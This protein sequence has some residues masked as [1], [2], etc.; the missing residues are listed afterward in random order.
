MSGF[1]FPVFLGL[2]LSF[3]RRRP[4]IGV[5]NEHDPVSDEY[6]ILNRH[7]FAYESVAG[8]LTVSPTFA[9]FWISTNAPITVRS[10]ISQP[11]KLINFDNLTLSPSLTS[12]EMH[13]YVSIIELVICAFARKN[14]GGSLQKNLYVKPYGPGGSVL[15]VQTDHIIEFHPASAANLPNPVIP[16]LTVSNRRLCHVS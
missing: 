12:G 10:P 8:D 13:R 3:G 6:V 15:E 1:H 5:V 14:S 2:K 11:Y 9:F 4:R 7:P 16:G